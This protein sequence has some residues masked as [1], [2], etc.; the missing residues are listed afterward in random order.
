MLCLI[1]SAGPS[2]RVEAD[3][4]SLHG[5]LCHLMKQQN[6]LALC[7]SMSAETVNSS[8]TRC[9]CPLR[10]AA[11]S[12]QGS[13]EGDWVRIQAENQASK[14]GQAHCPAAGP[15]QSESRRPW[16]EIPP[17]P[18][19]QLHLRTWCT[20]SSL[21]KRT[22]LLEV[23]EAAGPAEDEEPFASPQRRHTSMEAHYQCSSTLTQRADA[24]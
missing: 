2:C 3:G 14:K 24:S 12:S 16:A 19:P 15:G 20:R 7:A 1:C 5:D 10:P 22:P 9:G 8:P 18:S 11:A 13:A 17:N 23:F 4:I 6:S 21:R